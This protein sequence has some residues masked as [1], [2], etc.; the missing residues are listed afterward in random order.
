MSIKNYAIK[1]NEYVHEIP[2]K[3]ELGMRAPVKIFGNSSIYKKLDLGVF[4]QIVNVSK[5]P[6]LVGH[7]MTMP[8]AHWGYG[9]PIGGV[10]AF[11]VDEGVISPGGIGFDINCGMRMIT[12]N[13]TVD[14]VKPRIRELVNTLYTNIPTGIGKKGSVRLNMQ[15][16]R[17]VAELG[18][19]W[20]IEHGYGWDED[21]KKQEDNGRLPDA[22]F[23][24]VSQKAKSRGINQ[25]GTLGS[26]NHY[27]EVQR[28]N[29]I[30]DDNVAKTMGVKNKDQVVVMVH[31]GSRGFGHQ[32]A[33]DYLSEFLG[34]MKSQWN[35]PIY[36]RE[37]S[38][39]PINSR[40]GQNYFKAMSAAANYGFA[41]RQVIMSH[42]RKSFEQV[43]GRSAE[44]MNM[45]LVYDV[46]HN[47]AK[48]EIYPIEDKTR[49]VI[50]HRKGATRSFGPNRKEIP[51]VYQSIGQ[52]VILGGSMETGSY[53]LVGTKTAMKQSF[54]STAHGSGRTMSRSKAKKKIRGNI[55]R[56]QMEAKGIYV[57]AA[58]MAGLAEEA[59]FAY[60]NINDVVDS[61]HGADLSRKVAQLVPLGNIKG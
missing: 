46:A 34:K 10:A 52:P 19:K 54:G 29:Q 51:N 18:T 16:F 33:S 4:Q 30:F 32:I 2:E 47:I 35:I 61:I 25:L 45:R 53:L 24:A 9:F 42:V 41:N 39:A 27:C 12:T 20:C 28:V 23:S 38:A 56:S 48:R 59:G 50:V 3:A 43:L 55:L 17:D 5:L 6:G 60:K 11:D 44:D 40:E 37:L 31:C 8:D 21:L 58:S 13:L 1:K 26:G 22:D 14:E 36:E 7:A 49:K 57:R 15:Q